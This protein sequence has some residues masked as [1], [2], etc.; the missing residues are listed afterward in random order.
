MASSSLDLETARWLLDYE[1]KTGVLTW[2][3]RGAMDCPRDGG[4]RWN[5]RYAGREAF[6]IAPNGYRQGMVLRVMMRAHRLAW[7]M[8]YGEWPK[9]DI[10]HINGVRSDNRMCN[11]REVSRKENTRN[12]Q[13]R[14]TNK[15]GVTGVIQRGNRWHANVFHDGRQ[16]FLGS[17]QDKQDAIAARQKAS[18]DFGYHANHGRNP[19]SNERESGTSLRSAA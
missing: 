15:S 3:H 1:P 2:K 17:F 11:L 12:Q 13:I 10:D 19:I 16:I 18:S 4:K 14:N 7:F 9:G 5:G 8:H 6:R